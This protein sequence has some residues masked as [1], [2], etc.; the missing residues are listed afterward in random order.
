MD[1]VNCSRWLLK[2]CVRSI[3]SIDLQVGKSCNGCCPM[4]SPL[5]TWKISKS[6]GC[7]RKWN[8]PKKGKC[9]ILTCAHRPTTPNTLDP[10]SSSH[11]RTWWTQESQSQLT[12][13]L[14][15]RSHISTLLQQFSSPCPAPNS[16]SASTTSTSQARTKSQ[17]LTHNQ[18][19]KTITR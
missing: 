15:C 8:S 11:Q 6:T 2:I 14:Q 9:K 1:I 5:L 4:K 19:C 13:N 17:H 7:L 12:V 18:D 16:P 10:P 3:L